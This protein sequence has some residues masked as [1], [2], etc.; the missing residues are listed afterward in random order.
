MNEELI[1]SRAMFILD[2]AESLQASKYNPSKEEAFKA[3]ELALLSSALNTGGSIVNK[4]YDIEA[5]I[6]YL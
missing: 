5:A 1:E 6:G 4:L 3:I 2:I